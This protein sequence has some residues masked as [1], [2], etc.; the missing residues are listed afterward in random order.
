M[1]SSDTSAQ[2][3][4][5]LAPQLRAFLVAELNSFIKW[6]VVNLKQPLFVD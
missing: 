3:I 6:D 2:L 5:D 1:D 4:G